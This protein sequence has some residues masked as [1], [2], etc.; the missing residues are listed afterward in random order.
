MA[1]NYPHLVLVSDQD[2]EER[3]LHSALPVIVEFTANWCPPCRVLAPH[4]ARLS[5]SY[6]G[7]VTFVKMDTEENVLVPARLGIQGIPTLV[8][9]AGGR[10][11]G[12]LVGPHP[13]R[14]Q[15]SIDHLLAGVSAAVTREEGSPLVHRP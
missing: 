15:E 11:I 1:E 8:L 12:Y 3:V 13:G 6:Q 2:F 4:F 9:F 7:K 14:L 5:S 10:P